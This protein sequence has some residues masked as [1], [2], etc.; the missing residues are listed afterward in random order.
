MITGRDLLMIDELLLHEER[1]VNSP[2][3]RQI[4][5]LRQ[6]INNELHRIKFRIKKR[7]K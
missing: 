6:L 2:F 1:V 3:R 7:R 4:K 5:Y